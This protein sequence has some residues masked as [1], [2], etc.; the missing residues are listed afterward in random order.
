MS[1]CSVTTTA[2]NLVQQHPVVDLFTDIDHRLATRVRK[3]LD[4]GCGDNT[5]PSRRNAHVDNHVINSLR[6]LP[7]SAPN[8]RSARLGSAPS[9]SR[10][11]EKE[12]FIR[13]RHVYAGRGGW[14]KGSMS[15]STIINNNN[16]SSSNNNNKK[17]SSYDNNNDT[18]RKSNNINGN[19]SAARQRDRREQ[20][21]KLA[22][23]FRS[24]DHSNATWPTSTP[25][26]DS[27]PATRNR[28]DNDAPESR[29]GGETSE[30]KV[31]ASRRLA[32][33]TCVSAPKNS[34]S[35]GLGPCGRR[36]G[37]S[38]DW[39][40]EWSSGGSVP[41]DKDH[42][43]ERTCRSAIT[44]E[45]SQLANSRLVQTTTDR[46]QTTEIGQHLDGQND[47]DVDGNGRRLEPAD[48]GTWSER[49]NCRLVNGCSE[50]GFC[51][52]TSSEPEPGTG[53]RARDVSRST[54]D[55]DSPSL[56]SGRS[57]KSDAIEEASPPSGSSVGGGRVT[58]RLDGGDTR[59]TLL[60]QLSVEAQRALDETRQEMVSTD[61]KRCYGKTDR[62]RIPAEG[63]KKTP[64][65]QDLSQSNKLLLQQVNLLNMP[66]NVT[67]SSSASIRQLPAVSSRH[68]QQESRKS[69]SDM[70]HF[71][72]AYAKRQLKAAKSHPAE[73]GDAPEAGARV[74]ARA[75][76]VKVAHG[77]GESHIRHSTQG[78][79]RR[80]SLSQ[81]GGR[82]PQITSIDTSKL[83]RESELPWNSAHDVRIPGVIQYNRKT[84]QRLLSREHSFQITP[85][86]YDSRFSD[87]P[88]FT[89]ED[90][91][92]PNEVKTQAIEKCREWMQKYM[93]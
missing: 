66:Q 42:T 46:R 35:G 22:K 47:A 1:S 51:D 3:Q 75:P 18:N 17:G 62:D 14:F 26:G 84:T 30:R 73:K 54:N 91:D 28:P 52:E 69:L 5:E 13:Y 80:A 37:S 74:K 10:L 61:R 79:G 39:A 6:D 48:D 16:N 36:T 63:A 19:G 83:P 89:N 9:G 4:V 67:P 12:L 29:D 76:R 31:P 65:Y 20:L 32:T 57:K 87:L 7:H 50:G 56:T 40:V 24:G 77:P 45:D 82:L 92:T 88:I 53:H 71:R 44:D 59:M 58:C 8:P 85:L 27:D 64:D 72:S 41:I 33:R 90:D 43:E 68:R 21:S 55:V 34:A 78:Y 25:S 11:P 93:S 60:A 49:Q 23:R 81:S 38:I 86:G 70:S 2:T 15:S